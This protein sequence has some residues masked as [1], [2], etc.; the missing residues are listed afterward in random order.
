M[1]GRKPESLTIPSSDV[2]ELER[3]AHRDTSPWY[4]VRRARI[5]LGIAS[6][7]RQEDLAS[8][9]GCDEST[10]WRTCQRY[11]NLGLAGLLADHRQ[12]HSGRDLSITPVQRAQIVELAC[13]EPIARGLHITHWSSDDLACQA[14]RDGIVARISPAPG[15]SETSWPMSICSPTPPA[16]GRRPEW[17]PASRK[18][19]S[20]SKIAQCTR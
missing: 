14:V 15:P 16:T 12:G 2:I 13:L 20:K 17:T 18:G 8:Q 1:R 5:I 19:R 3:V 7:Q 4:Q 9:L 11:R 6:G 10:V